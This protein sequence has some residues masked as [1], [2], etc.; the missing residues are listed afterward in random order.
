[1]KICFTVGSVVATLE[2]LNMIRALVAVWELYIF[3]DDTLYFS[4]PTFKKNETHLLS[5]SWILDPYRKVL[6][7]CKFHS[8]LEAFAW[9]AIYFLVFKFF[10]FF[11]HQHL[12]DF[13]VFV[14]F[15]VRGLWNY[16]RLTISANNKCNNKWRGKFPVQRK[17][18]KRK[19]FFHMLA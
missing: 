5:T 17:L 18:W 13:Y 9:L 4:A 1:M 10:V 7:G 16:Y 11:L 2:I 3:R 15:S 6:A 12:F 19:H 14:L 8:A